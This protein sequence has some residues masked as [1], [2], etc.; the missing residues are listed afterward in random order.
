[1]WNGTLTHNIGLLRRTVHWRD[2]P[3]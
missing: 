2:H 1:M 3:E